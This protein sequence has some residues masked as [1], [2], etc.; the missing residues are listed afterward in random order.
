M[1][2]WYPCPLTTNTLSRC[3][4]Y[5]IVRTTSGCRLYARATEFERPLMTGTEPECRE[6]AA[7]G[8]LLNYVTW[9]GRLV[10]SSIDTAKP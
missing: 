9:P 4:R 7:E 3:G 2:D 5:R 10:P 1:I 8:E 6:L